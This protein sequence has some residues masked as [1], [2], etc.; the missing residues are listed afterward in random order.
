MFSFSSATSISKTLLT[1]HA[2]GGSNRGNAL[3][4]LYVDATIDTGCGEFSWHVDAPPL[5]ETPPP[6]PPAKPTLGP[7]VCHDAHKHQDVQKAWVDTWSLFGCKL[8]EK[9]KAGDKEIYWHPVGG[10]YEQNYKISWIEGCT[11]AQEQS[12]EHPIEDDQSIY[13]GDLFKLNYYNCK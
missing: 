12:V 11:V 1:A 10:E 5:E 8:S 2:P 13:C 7:R 3:N 6:P 9:M 4:R